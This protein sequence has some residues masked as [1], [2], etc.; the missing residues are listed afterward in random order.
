MTEAS[1]EPGAGPHADP[2]LSRAT[3]WGV[4]WAF[5]ATGLSRLVWLAALAVLARLLAPEEFGRFALALVFLTYVETVGDLGAGF[6]VVHW[7]RRV[8]DAAQVA[9]HLNLATGAAW[10]ALSW[11]LAPG[12]AEFFRDP[13]AVPLIRAL[14]VGFLVKALGNT[15][16]ALCQRELRFKAR[17]VPE[18]A[19]TGAKGAVAVALALLGYGVW[20]LVWGQL[21]GLAFQTV[22]LWL[23]VPWRPGLRLAWDR[24]GD[25]VWPMLVYGAGIV[26]VHALAAVARHADLVVVGR[27]LGT[28]ALGFYQMATKVPEV[29]LTLGV[30]VTSRVLFSAFSRAHAGGA[31]PE[32]VTRG[33]LTAF[34]YLSR[35]AIPAA[36][37]LALVAEPLVRTLFGEDWLPSVPILRALAVYVGIRSLGMPGG[38]VLKATGRLGPLFALRCFEAVL[39]VPALI[40]AGRWSGLAVAVTLAAVTAVTTLVKLGVVARRVGVPVRR[41]AGAAAPSFAGSAALAAALAGWQVWGP[42]LPPAADLAV[43]ALA[44]AAVYAGVLALLEPGLA[45]E[46]RELLRSDDPAARGRGSGPPGRGRSA[47]PCR[48]PSPPG[49]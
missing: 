45:G 26:A 11:W 48:G 22:A 6:A 14:A 33:F 34:R 27:L 21:A 49:A 39:L 35:I 32:R 3:A 38:D 16:D 42:S 2:A 31:D 12:V 4:V 36:A 23:E 9:F 17:L 41:L 46:L 19:L 20:S 24:V 40:A 10:L 47:G 28:T 29:S 1:P 18:I 25:L 15:H 44:G 13:E 37:G 5:L 8:R 7:P 43:Q 30:W